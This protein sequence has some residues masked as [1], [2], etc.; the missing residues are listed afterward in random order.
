MDYNKIIISLMI[1]LAVF[2]VGGFLFLNQHNTVVNTVAVQNNTSSSINVEKINSEDVV[3]SN[4]GDS[5]QSSGS[6]SK[7]VS[8]EYA[9]QHQSEWQSGRGYY[10]VGDTQYDSATG[11]IIGGGSAEDQ[12]AL[13]E[14]YG[15]R[16]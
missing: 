8:K 9:K 12:E 13:R 4:A 11:K 1:I 14:V 10:W 6:D 16:I 15:D 2:A 7:Y 5:Q 3:N